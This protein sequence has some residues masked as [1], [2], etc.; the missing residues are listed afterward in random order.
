M[1]WIETRSL[2]DSSQLET[3]RF[4]SERSKTAIL[5]CGYRTKYGYDTSGNLTTVTDQAGLVTTLEYGAP[6]ALPTKVTSPASGPVVFHRDNLLRL[7]KAMPNFG[8]QPARKTGYAYDDALGQVTVAPSGLGEVVV[9]YDGDGLVT[10]VKAADGGVTKYLDY[11][12]RGRPLVVNTPDSTTHAYTYDAVGGLVD[13]VITVD[14]GTAG[15]TAAPCFIVGAKCVNGEV[16]TYDTLGRLTSRID[17]NGTTSFTYR[18]SDGLLDRV[19]YQD[20]AWLQH[21]YYTNGA[22]RRVTTSD[23]VTK[24]LTYNALGIHSVSEIHQGVTQS[25]EFERDATGRVLSER[26]LL[27]AVEVD[28]HDARYL[29]NGLVKRIDNMHYARDPTTGRV[30]CV[31]I[32]A[33]TD[34]SGDLL[35]PDATY[36]RLCF[37]YN[38]FGEVIREYGATGGLSQSTTHYSSGLPNTITGPSGV[39]SF[40]Y[41]PTGKPSSVTEPTGLVSA[42]GYDLSGRLAWIDSSREGRLSYHHDAAGNLR[43]VRAHDYLDQP[44]VVIEDRTFDGS[45]QLQRPDAADPAELMYDARGNVISVPEPQQAYT[46]DVLGRLMTTVGGGGSGSAFGYDALDR[47]VRDINLDTG[48][49]RV[50]SHFGIWA[51]AMRTDGV[52]RRLVPSLGVNGP[53]A[54]FGG[55]EYE[56]PTWQYGTMVERNSL[57]GANSSGEEWS[58]YGEVLGGD[59]DTFPFGFKGY[60]KHLGRDAHWAHTRTYSATNKYFLSPDAWSGTPADPGTMNRHR[61]FRGDPVGLTDVLGL[62]ENSDLWVHCPPDCATGGTSAADVSV[63]VGSLIEWLFGSEEGGGGSGSV[64]G[65]AP[66]PSTLPPPPGATPPPVLPPVPGGGGTGGSG[67]VPTLAPPGG[68]PASAGPAFAGAGTGGLGFGADSGEGFFE[69]PTW[70]GIPAAFVQGGIEGTS[71]LLLMGGGGSLL[72]DPTKSPAWNRANV[73]LGTLARDPPREGAAGE[74]FT[75]ARETSDFV[76]RFARNPRGTVEDAAAGLANA[77][78]AMDAAERAR[79]VGQLAPGAAAALVPMPGTTTCFS[80]DT[81]VSTSEGPVEIQ[82]IEAGDLVWAEDTQT[83]DISLHEVLRVTKRVADGV[84]RLRLSGRTLTTTQ[85]HPFWVDGNGWVD[86]GELRE[87]DNLWTIAGGHVAVE[88]V[89]ADYGPAIVYNL[90]VDGLHTYFVSDA[91]VL[92]HNKLGNTILRALR[93]A[94]R[95]VPDEIVTR[96]ERAVRGIGPGAASKLEYLTVEEAA[97]FASAQS[98]TFFEVEEALANVLGEEI[99]A[100]TRLGPIGIV[101]NPGVA[102]DLARLGYDAAEFRLVQYEVTGLHGTYLVDVFE[103]ESAVGG[104]FFGPH[105]SS[106]NFK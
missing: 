10:R 76:A 77:W 30:D 11:D 22:L 67:F 98:R 84:V 50:L 23:G 63:D 1:E 90:E 12:P 21:D 6:Y 58:A 106:T 54:M 27:G 99:I 74:L 34:A 19:T 43:Q 57:S 17:T 36:D 61:V 96:G 103:T 92:V 65:A 28:Y 29:P 79:F 20:G 47:L 86:A 78:G 55:G 39:R 46:Y 105:L 7:T 91:E 87:G 69:T 68:G 31:E 93:V 64:P 94:D 104:V 14:P 9:G 24:G 37:D 18:S 32:R 5:G 15:A 44:G 81:V 49:D 2:S 38:V 48:R 72:W 95:L 85:E 56:V 88:S 82:Q 71:D 62:Q 53:V 45:N 35:D 4:V 26:T 16:A 51:V 33:R 42:Y 13:H 100:A 83:A 102:A 59:A 97:A 60:Y 70:S 40:T 101:K 66:A 3:R 8:G 73:T 41:Y 89:E 80:G 75:R 25:V 52:L